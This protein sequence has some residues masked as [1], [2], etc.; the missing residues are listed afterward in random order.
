MKFSIITVCFN[1]AATIR[2]TIESVFS[3]DYPNI[4]YIIVDGASK[5]N[6]LSIVNEY[7]DRITT[8]ISEPDKGLYDAM[9][10]GIGLATGD[11][12]GILNSD[13]VL[14]DNVTISKIADALKVVDGVYGDVGFYDSALV[15][16]T[17]HYSSKGFH[18]RKF[19]RGFMPAHPSCYF[20]RS[21]IDKVGFYSLEFKI[22]SDFD[23]L[24]RAFS[25]SDSE[26]RYLPLEI[27]KMREGGISTAG[28][29]ANILLNQEIIKSCR[30]NGLPCTW[31]SVL[32]KYPEK[33]MGLIFK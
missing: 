21:L 3:Q 17:R 1:S 31:L 24:V 10:K 8:V 2:D 7:Q 9:N 5:D 29:S 6:T 16:K 26:F 19:A 25:I 13:D 15:K 33:I 18:R 11:V 14:A 32:S 27:V 30:N 12:I 23:F 22:A 28:F 4:E 20:K